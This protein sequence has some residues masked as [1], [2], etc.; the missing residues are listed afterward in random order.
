MIGASGL[1][2]LRERVSTLSLS[3]IF[4]ASFALLLVAQL[5]LTVNVLRYGFDQYS[6][7]SR[8]QFTPIAKSILIAL[9]S[10]PDRLLL[11][12]DPPSIA[13]QRTLGLALM[14]APLVT[15]RLSVAEWD[16]LHTCRR[17]F[18]AP[19]QLPLDI[20]LGVLAKKRRWGP[21]YKQTG[22]FI[23]LALVMQRPP[24][25]NFTDETGDLAKADR[26]ELEFR[27]GERS[28]R[29]AIVNKLAQSRAADPMTPTAYGIDAG[30]SPKNPIPDALC[31]LRFDPAVT[32]R[33]VYLCRIPKKHVPVVDAVTPI[34]PP[35]EALR[36]RLRI[37]AAVIERQADGIG[38]RPVASNYIVRDGRVTDLAG[39]ALLSMDQ[40]MEQAAKPGLQACIIAG[41]G[42]VLW[43][44]QDLA[45]PARQLQRTS[46]PEAQAEASGGWWVLAGML[47][48]SQQVTREF[49]I[50][51]AH[52]PKLWLHY[53]ETRLA[54]SWLPTN[55]SPTLPLVLLMIATCLVYL[56]VFRWVLQ[57]IQ[58]LSSAVEAASID[59]T[60]RVV[61][62]QTSASDEIGILTRAF[63]ALL[64]RVTDVVELEIN[65]LRMIGH[66]I[67]S[68]LQSL[69]AMPQTE[70]SYRQ[71]KR[72]QNAIERFEASRGARE[73]FD[74]VEIGTTRE[75]VAAFLS[76]IVDNA[77]RY[78]TFDGLEY[79]GPKA[80]V[81]IDADAALLEDVVAH[82]LDNGRRYRHPGTI[83]FIDLH[84]AAGRVTISIRNTGPA[85][86]EGMEKEIF[87]YGVT[88][89]G[90]ASA[91]LGQG[92]YAAKTFVTMMAG[93]IEA[94]NLPDG[95]VF[96][97]NLPVAG[98][99]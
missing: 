29:I 42:R 82:I 75:D 51:G 38:L 84:E 53:D 63:N 87:E 45:C 66:D 86:P 10:T 80:G 19:S 4:H 93:S 55:T 91:S 56:I 79:R 35:D 69:L 49:P 26:I 60:R 12:N 20:C 1:A 77:Q 37:R 17:R 28:S 73:A 43:P 8:S 74:Q 5:F 61:I 95:V 83:I 27:L 14:D 7:Q 13:E 24:L 41:D 22:K 36:A 18:E 48:D 81:W 89:Q 33:S 39:K 72:I 23:Y 31:R 96:Q 67:R 21:D 11:V 46:G 99:D 25:A 70:G 16:E 65:N 3:W 54:A 88:T 34:W 71:I 90:R 57:P 44:R 68:P 30:S 15:N 97:I 76:D 2:R 98:G 50:N 85:L 64:A 52:G 40:L 62:P 94:F 78:A 92:L 6:R 47:F 32:P 58:R 59:L 9:R